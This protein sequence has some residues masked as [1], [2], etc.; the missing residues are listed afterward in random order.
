[1][2]CGGSTQK[3]NRAGQLGLALALTWSSIPKIMSILMCERTDKGIVQMMD[4]VR[5]NMLKVSWPSKI[6]ACEYH[7][8]LFF[9]AE[10]F[11]YG[12]FWSSASKLD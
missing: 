10:G 12:F 2:G 7:L 9:C 6:D 3:R 4:E 1:M 8:S 5:L 11:D